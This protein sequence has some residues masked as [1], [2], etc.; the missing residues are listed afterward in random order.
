MSDTPYTP[1]TEAIRAAWRYAMTGE[2][3]PDAAADAA[4]DRYID[5]QKTRAINIG[6]IA[7]QETMQASLE[8][9]LRFVQ[10]ATLRAAADEVDHRESREAAA[11]YLRGRAD[12]VEAG[13]VPAGEDGDDE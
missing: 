12:E 8:E 6:H 2:T 7:A 11:A 9:A 4:L 3:T 13:P 10:A 5:Q 1:D